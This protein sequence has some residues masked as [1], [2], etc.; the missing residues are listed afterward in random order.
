MRGKWEELLIWAPI[1][2][3]SLLLPPGWA[4]NRGYRGKAQQRGMMCLLGMCC[5][6]L[7]QPAAW[8]GKEQVIQGERERE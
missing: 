4:G 6:G 1:Y 8:K 7:I 2:I 5:F 3:Y